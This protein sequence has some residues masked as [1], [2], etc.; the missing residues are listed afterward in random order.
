MILNIILF[1]IF[2]LICIFIAMYFRKFINYKLYSTFS[3]YFVI[4]IVFLLV[5]TIMIY[6]AQSVDAA[7][8]GLIIWA[9]LVIRPCFHFYWFRIIDQSR[10]CQIYRHNTRANNETCF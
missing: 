6:P 2:V 4:L 8:N 10:C 3:N 5:I 7:Y 9:T 1:I